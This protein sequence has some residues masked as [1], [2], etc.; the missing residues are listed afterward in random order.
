MGGGAGTRGA[1]KPFD[2]SSTTAVRRH[3]R[4]LCQFNY[5]VI[6]QWRHGER[7][8]RRRQTFSLPKEARPLKGKQMREVKK[9]EAEG[10]SPFNQHSS[11]KWPFSLRERPS[12]IIQGWWVDNKA[13]RKN[14]DVG[15]EFLNTPPFAFTLRAII[16]RTDGTPSCTTRT[17][18]LLPA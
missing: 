10:E 12:E 15:Q 18:L 14:V 1:P 9:R 13:H 3:P 11:I 5:Y 16:L 8:S 2:A 6:K 4:S 7:K 17:A